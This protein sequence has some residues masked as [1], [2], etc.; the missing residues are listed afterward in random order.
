MQIRFPHFLIA[1]IAAWL[2]REQQAVIDY[3]K[4]ENKV[5]R[6]QLGDHRIRFTD[7]QRRRLA[8]SGL[9]AIS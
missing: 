5:L 6:E 7:S 1:I 3:L 4:E 2:G 8:R 9:G